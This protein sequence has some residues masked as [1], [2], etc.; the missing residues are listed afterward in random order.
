MK[1]QIQILFAAA[2]IVLALWIAGQI[3]QQIAGGLMTVLEFVG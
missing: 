2:V 3:V 1:E